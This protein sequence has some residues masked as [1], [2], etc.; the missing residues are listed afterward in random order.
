[1]DVTAV[2]EN[3]P[4]A[5]E[6]P[7]HG[8]REAG[9]HRLEPARQVPRAGRLD[10]QVHVVALHRVLDD[11]EA[12]AVPDLPPAPLELGQVPARPQRGHVPVDA[13]GDVAGMPRGERS[14]SPVRIAR[15]GPRLA[16]GAGSPA[17]PAR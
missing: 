6:H 8:P 15:P 16:P 7:I 11:P 5:P 9:H 12:R 4:G 17:S 10:Q 13:E 1:V 3:L 14:P 2:G